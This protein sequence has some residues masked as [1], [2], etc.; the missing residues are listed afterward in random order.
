MNGV[1]DVSANTAVVLNVCWSAPATME[2]CLDWLVDVPSYATHHDTTL[3]R[4]VQFTENQ[5]FCVDTAQRDVQ[6][7]LF[8]VEWKLGL[9]DLQVR[10]HT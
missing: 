9:R 8:F 1:E 2:A 10:Y 6:L 5:A 3:R 7:D 4:A